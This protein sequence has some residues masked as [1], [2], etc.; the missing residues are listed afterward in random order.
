MKG[1]DGGILFDALADCRI[2][3]PVPIEAHVVP[4]GVHLLIGEGGVLLDNHGALWAV[5][6]RHPVV[7]GVEGHLLPSAGLFVLHIPGAGSI[8]IGLADVV[9]QGHDDNALIRDGVHHFPRG[10]VLPAAIAL[11]PKQEAP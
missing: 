8:E 3:V 10:K 5:A 11:V 9:E 2:V 1:K 4:Y 6:Q 7:H